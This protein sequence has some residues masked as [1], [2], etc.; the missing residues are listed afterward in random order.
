[1]SHIFPVV[2]SPKF[3]VFCLEAV[4][5]VLFQQDRLRTPAQTL[6]HIARQSLNQELVMFQTEIASIYTT[7]MVLLY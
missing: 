1:M 5:V 6:K 3:C 7:K 2:T 4:A